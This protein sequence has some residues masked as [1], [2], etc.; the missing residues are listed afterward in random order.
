MMETRL[1]FLLYGSDYFARVS[2]GGT[3]ETV[4]LLFG[5]DTYPDFDQSF[6]LDELNTLI[7]MLS[8]ARDDLDSR[9][10]TKGE[11]E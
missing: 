2:F 3:R 5:S 4:R 10:P 9:Q 11:P 8:V 6:E 7:H 1:S